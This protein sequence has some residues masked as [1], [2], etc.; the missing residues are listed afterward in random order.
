MLKAKAIIFGPKD[1]PYEN[2]ILYFIIE[3]PTDYPFNPPKIGYYSHSRYRIHPNLYVGKSY[4]N[5]LG[6]VC[7]SVI[8]TW[9]G[10]K[11]TTVMHIGSI[12]LS[13]QSLLCKNPLHN[14]PGYEK[15]VGNR[16]DLYN[17]VVEYDNYQ[18]LILENGLNISSEFKEFNDI[19]HEHLN[20]NKDKIIE[21][22]NRLS[23][24]DPN[25]INISLNIYNINMTINYPELKNKIIK[26]FDIN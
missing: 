2:G 17:K 16:N 12:L 20:I 7:L 19:I 9:S 11:W 6:K 10:P 1:T 25:K 8:N 4:D 14:E 13:I 24:K 21:N 22:L 18:Y 26:K 3:F 23:K 5:Y 15:E